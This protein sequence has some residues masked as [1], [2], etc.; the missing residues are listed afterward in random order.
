LIYRSSW[1]VCRCAFVG[2]NNHV[3]GDRNPCVPSYATCVP[4]ERVDNREA[5]WSCERRK[6][7]CV[8]IR[9][10]GGKHHDQVSVCRIEDKLGGIG[11]YGGVMLN[12][13]EGGEN[14]NVSGG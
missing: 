13:W 3:G 4:S 11:F 10:H 1:S 8:G 5:I 2:N 14:I 12:Y 9:R 6:V 7:S